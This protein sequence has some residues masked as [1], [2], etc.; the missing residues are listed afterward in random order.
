[1]LVRKELFKI[2]RL[3]KSHGIKGEITLFFDESAYADIET[4]FYFLDIES[5]FVPFLIEEITITGETAG[6]VKFEDIDDET[7]AS[8]FSNIEIYIRRDDL[9]ELADST[10]AGWNYLVGFSVFDQ[11]N[12][13]L[14]TIDHVDTSTINN[15]FILKNGDDE[16][17]IPATEDFIIE[18]DEEEKKVFMRLPDGLIDESRSILVES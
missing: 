15:L 2:G 7:S 3:Q 9:P 5:I 11:N 8:R 6:R 17:L 18:V 4:E 14:G 16:L 13:E 10:A 1:M 12:S